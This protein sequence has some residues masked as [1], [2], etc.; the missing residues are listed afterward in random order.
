MHS[1]SPNH[2]TAT[3]SHCNVTVTVAVLSL[4][5]TVTMQPLCSRYTVAV[6]PLY[7]GCVYD[8]YSDWLQHCLHTVGY[9]DCTATFGSLIITADLLSSYSFVPGYSAAV[10]LEPFNSKWPTTKGYT[11]CVWL[12]L[13]L[14]ST[15]PQ[16]T[17][18]DRRVI[19]SMTAK[20]DHEVSLLLCGDRLVLYSN[21]KG[22]PVEC[23]LDVEGTSTSR[24]RCGKW[25]F[26]AVCHRRDDHAFARIM[27]SRSEVT[28]YI[29]AQQVYSAAMDFPSSFV[30][31]AVAVGA[32]ANKPTS[33]QF[34][35]GAMLLLNGALAVQE[36]ALLKK[37]GP[38]SRRSAMPAS[39]DDA[40]HAVLSKVVRELSPMMCSKLTRPADSSA[41]FGRVD[42]ATQPGTPLYPR[43]D[44][45]VLYAQRRTLQDSVRCLGGVAVLLPLLSRRGI[46]DEPASNNLRVDTEV[47]VS[48]AVMTL[49]AECIKSSEANQEEVVQM[50][51]VSVLAYLLREDR[52]ITLCLYTC[53]YASSKHTLNRSIML[54]TEVLIPILSLAEH[55]SLDERLRHELYQHVLFDFS[56][57][58]IADFDVLVMLLLKLR[59]QI[60][61][62]PGARRFTKSIGAHGVADLVYRHF[63][64]STRNK[65]ARL[66]MSE[67]SR[68]RRLALVLIREATHGEWAA[69]ECAVLVHIL[70]E[71]DSD[72]ELATDVMNM[73]IEVLVGFDTSAGVE[74]QAAPQ[75]F[76]KEMRSLKLELV[77]LDLVSS[78][79]DELQLVALQCLAV[80]MGEANDRWRKDFEK[81]K[82]FHMLGAALCQSYIGNAPNTLS[83]PKYHALLDLLLATK[84]GTAWCMHRRDGGEISLRYQPIMLDGK[85]KIVNAA[86]LGT[87]FSVLLYAELQ[88][89][90]RALQDLCLLL[91]FG[92]D[93][94]SC[95]FAE[96][97]WP[98]WLFDLLA[99]PQRRPATGVPDPSMATYTSGADSPAGSSSARAAS[100]G[101]AESDAYASEVSAASTVGRRLSKHD[102]AASSSCDQASVL[103]EQ[104][105]QVFA[106]AFRHS[107]VHQSL[108]SETWP[109][110]WKDLQHVL[111]SLALTRDIQPGSGANHIDALAAQVFESAF[112][113]VRENVALFV[114]S[115]V[116]SHD[117]GGSSAAHAVLGLEVHKTR[118]APSISLCENFH[119]LILALDDFVTFDAVSRA[120][121]QHTP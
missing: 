13:E 25:Y 94:R 111:V 63:G 6:Q 33:L 16:P 90:H 9:T 1:Y 3:V 97:C 116:A 110:G 73:M 52:S 12:R 36:V 35:L 121:R 2:C 85:Q 104:V 108:R 40:V 117:E 31:S 100:F 53:L 34:Q 37:L 39:R 58:L 95:F 19:F 103:H 24:L 74:S 41:D 47:D 7:S 81:D 72:A 64:P 70:S 106:V 11:I 15:K 65:H 102:D 50:Q 82:G 79:A 76:L 23:V 32:L 56:L 83:L 8:S 118:H 84:P 78:T 115:N 87:L 105:F 54:S 43:I 91:S 69:G 99:V 48:G 59:D 114:V 112:S 10:H 42:S 57:W 66:S 49:L 5:L 38:N 98:K 113:A 51:M 119:S 21:S 77:L 68:V 17:G 86:A 62:Q 44:G 14:G 92:D 30:P 45:S 67:L 107:V 27:K 22:R 18:A 101:R 80:V 88:L 26:V 75:S 60:A 28:W 46:A 96:R 4:P 29:D 89:Q 93:N 71:A 20:P 61:H 55:R 120:P 109:C